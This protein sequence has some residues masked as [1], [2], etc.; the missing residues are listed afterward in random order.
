[1]TKVM[2][3]HSVI[4]RFSGFSYAGYC[5]VCVEQEVPLSSL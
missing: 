1:M 3:C 4:V 5:L 2:N